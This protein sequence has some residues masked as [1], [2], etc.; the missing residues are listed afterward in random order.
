MSVDR[1][2]PLPVIKYG[3]I[4]IL[5]AKREIVVGKI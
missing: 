5:G 4:F 1:R 3:E 2:K